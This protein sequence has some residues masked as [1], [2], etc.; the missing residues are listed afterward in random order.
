MR[1][2]GMRWLDGITDSMDMSLNR[3]RE[4]WWW[5]GRPAVPQSMG[6]RRVRHYWA[7]E[8]NWNNQKN[9]TEYIKDQFSRHLTLGNARKWSDPWEAANKVSCTI[10]PVCCLAGPQATAQGR[11]PRKTL[12][13]TLSASKDGSKDGA[14][15]PGGPR[16]SGWQ[17]LFQRRR[18][19]QGQLRRRPQD[20]PQVFPKGLVPACVWGHYSRPVRESS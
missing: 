8:L 13:I 14:E 20:A 17:A 10:C 2:H 7:T 6:S 9:Q 16:C 18:A 19:A 1:A 11:G 4:P 12:G 5:T 3:L 15:R